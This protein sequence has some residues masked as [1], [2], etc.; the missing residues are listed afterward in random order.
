[1]LDHKTSLNKLKKTKIIPEI[2]CKYNRMKP[3][4]DSICEML[5]TEQAN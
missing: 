1:M 5:T 3:V 2:F 4:I